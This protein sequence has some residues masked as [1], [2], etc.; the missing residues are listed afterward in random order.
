MELNGLVTT[1]AA[2]TGFLIPTH[3]SAQFKPFL[4]LSMRG[5]H[6]T[7]RFNHR[8]IRFTLMDC[9]RR[10]ASQPPLMNSSTNMSTKSKQE[11]LIKECVLTHTVRS[12]PTLTYFP[13]RDPSPISPSLSFLPR[14]N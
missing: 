9:M 11:I 8:V 5:N 7:S 10:L 6:V 4:H 12:R 1:K 13:L 14:R 2:T 3:P